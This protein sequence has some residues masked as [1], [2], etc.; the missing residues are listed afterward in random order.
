LAINHVKRW[1]PVA[2]A[3]Q[4]VASYT[5]AVKTF[6]GLKTTYEAALTAYDAA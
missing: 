4:Q 1:F 2:Y 3:E 5:S 6:N